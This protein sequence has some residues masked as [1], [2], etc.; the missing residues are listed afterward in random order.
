M[1]FDSISTQKPGLEPRISRCFYSTDLIWL[2]PKMLLFV[3]QANG[4][5]NH[6][7]YC[8]HTK[9]NDMATEAQI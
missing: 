1:A 8:P 9:Q 2:M 6:S 3:F 4:R 7:V 5:S